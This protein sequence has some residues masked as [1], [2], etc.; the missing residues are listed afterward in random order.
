MTVHLVRRNAKNVP[1]ANEEALASIGEQD[2]T[3]HNIGPRASKSSFPTEEPDSRI[4]KGYYG[5]KGS[6][7]PNPS[8]IKPKACAEEEEMSKNEQRESRLPGYTVEDNP[9][10]GKPKSQKGKAPRCQGQSPQ[11]SQRKSRA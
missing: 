1:W 3:D 4:L 2:S 9:V 11:A 5:A 6:G 7:D 8:Y 10:L